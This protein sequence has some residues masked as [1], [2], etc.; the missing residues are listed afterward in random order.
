MRVCLRHRAGLFLALY[1]LGSYSMPSQTAATCRQ[2][3]QVQP[4][5][6]HVGRVMM[7]SK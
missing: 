6:A 3:D 2:E 7:V 1:V 5:S 4:V